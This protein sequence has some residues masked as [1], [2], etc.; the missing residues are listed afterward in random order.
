[1]LNVARASQLLFYPEFLPDAHRG[2]DCQR[3][4]GGSARGRV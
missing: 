4:G 1:M 2:W 3:I